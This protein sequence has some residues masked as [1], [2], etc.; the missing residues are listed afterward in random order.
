VQLASFA[1]RARTDHIL[2]EWETTNELGVG[3]YHLYRTVAAGG[4][5]TR[6]NAA[7]IP[8]QA[9]GSSSG[10]SY[11]WNDSAVARGAT[12]RYRVVTVGLDGQETSLEAV[13]V[14]T[15]YWV[16]APVVGR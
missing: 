5:W 8:S 4:A 14:S 15:P 2:L 7:M 3:G 6:L 12:Y 10:Y 9:P 11:R 16:W 13:Q 1:A